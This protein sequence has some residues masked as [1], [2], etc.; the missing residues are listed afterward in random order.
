MKKGYRLWSAGAATLI[1]LGFFLPWI[2]KTP[3]SCSGF[4]LSMM[5]FAFLWL[6]PLSSVG[7]ALPMVLKKKPR[8]FHLLY[9]AIISALPLVILICT[10]I[11]QDTGTLTLAW[12]SDTMEI[13]RLS[14]RGET[15]LLNPV[16]DL[17]IGLILSLGGIALQ[18][19]IP[20]F[21][22]S[23]YSLAGSEEPTYRTVIKPS[24]ISAEYKRS[25]VIFLCAAIL[26]VTYVWCGMSPL[27]L[28]ENR[29]HAREYLFGRVL[30]AQ[31]LAEVEARARRAP[32]IEAEGL[33]REYMSNKYRDVPFQEQPDA[34][35]KREEREEVK[36]QILSRMAPRKI[37]NLIKEAR[38][39][40]LKNKKGG[41]F[42]PETAWPKIK[43]Y[44]VALLETVAI[45][46]WGTLLALICAIP[47]SFFAAQNTLG[48]IF[49]SDDLRSRSLKNSISFF[50][51]RFLDSCRGFNEFVM[52]LIFVAV[53]G[54]GPYAGIL[55]L[56]IHTFGI[57]GKVFSEQIEA[58]ESGQVEALTSTGASAT[59][60]IAF[61]VM[62]QVLPT[63]V[64]YTLLRFE[65]NVRSAAILGFVG[66]GGIGFLIFD[67]LNGYLFRE[68]CTMMIIIIIT[69]G[70]IDHLC[71]RI[72]M[73][74]I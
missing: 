68:V 73:R 38:R 21:F 53:I 14:T 42:P 55:A 23:I 35:R 2:G 6:L 52:A 54:L 18:S 50:V 70:I 74:F 44:L 46:I 36:Q 64:S 17:G 19:L 5:G 61:S 24:G 30:S 59:Q 62:P 51:R 9:P 7:V 16:T 39:T 10:M 1:L 25:T 58:I 40:A 20:F 49:P 69:V 41:Y 28:W 67:K 63:F 37:E 66:A 56:W 72:R 29:G 45:A 60:A 13:L 3:V 27:K 48:L 4:S 22:K 15:H 31:D 57:L 26:A 12:P 34:A 47:I 11:V 43:G 71:S 32:N 8:P 65:S 33:A